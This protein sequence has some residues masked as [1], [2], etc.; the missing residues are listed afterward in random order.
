M[1]PVLGVV[2]VLSWM[3]RCQGHEIPNYQSDWGREHPAPQ[4]G[5]DD[6]G[7]ETDDDD[8]D[9]PKGLY[10]TGSCRR[11]AQSVWPYRPKY[12]LWSDG[13]DKD[14]YIYLPPGT[15]IDTTNADRWTF[16]QG[17]RIYKTFTIDDVRVE[18]RVIEKVGVAAGIDSWTF[19]AYAWSEDQHS[20]SPADPKGVSD[21]LGTQHD[22]P[23]Q[24][25]CRS[26]HTM[27]GLDAVNAFGAIQLNHF[28]SGVTLRRLIDAG[29]LVNGAGNPPNVSVESA[30]IPGDPT[31]QAALGYLHANCGHC[32][33]GPTPRLGFKLWSTVGMKQVSDAPI[34]ETGCQC[35]TKWTGRQN[36][37][38]QAYMVRVDPGHAADSGIIG[39]MSVRGAGEQMPPFGTDQVDQTAV[40]A[41]SAFIDALDPTVCA[42]PM[43]CTAP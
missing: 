18:T 14:R 5:D 6:G 16:P 15:T 37:Q 41:V 23:S 1:K 43:P 24:A 3:A 26:C 35:L 8:C 21:V 17:T 30:R 42:M 10:E 40:R 36:A 27:P 11:L 19:T 28:A 39:R 32:H 38:G 7:I 34:F 22:I 4:R 20:V 25:Q 13:A 33:G 31:A 2:A 12:E 29:L 9:G